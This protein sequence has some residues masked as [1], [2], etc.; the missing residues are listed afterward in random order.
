M[1][2]EGVFNTIQNIS[3]S[4]ICN[5]L[6]I[7]SNTKCNV[8]VIDYFNLDFNRIFWNIFK[9]LI[10]FSLERYIHSFVYAYY[11]L[12]YYYLNHISLKFISHLLS[13]FDS[14]KSNFLFRLQ[15]HDQSL[16]YFS[17]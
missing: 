15:K 6:L 7:L 3:K 1:L 10:V 13:L 11:V 9:N 5:V 12:Y 4:Y 16:D 2:I 8:I 14:P 17:T